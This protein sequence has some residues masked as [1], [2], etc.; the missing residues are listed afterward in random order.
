MDRSL[1]FTLLLGLPTLLFT[2]PATAQE[3]FEGHPS[4][5]A[6]SLQTLYG[7]MEA[8]P[9]HMA[10]IDGGRSGQRALHIEGGEEKMIE[11]LLDERPQEE[12]TLHFWLQRVTEEEPFSLTVE[13]LDE[14][15]RTLA[16][17]A[18]PGAKTGTWATEVK[19]TLPPATAAVRISC[20][21]SQGGGANIDDLSISGGTVM[22][23]GD[24]YARDPGAL[25][26]MKGRCYN[27]VYGLCIPTTGSL[28][29]RRLNRVNVRFS[30]SPEDIEAVT[31]HIGSADPANL[32]VAR[33]T[34]GVSIKPTRDK[35]QLVFTGDWPL[36]TGDN[37]IWISA[38]PSASADIHRT[39]SCTP[40]SIVLENTTVELP[41]T[42]E[43][44]Q[45]IGSAVCTSGDMNAKYFRLPGVIRTQKGTLVACFDARYNH[46]GNLPA[47]IDIAFSRSEDGGQTWSPPAVAMDTGNNPEAGYDG[48]GD[49]CIL[50]DAQNGRIWIAALWVHGNW[51]HAFNGS[52][53]GLSPDDT[54][55][56]VMVTSDDDGR[57]WSRKIINITPQIKNP[58]WRLVL[59]GPGMGICTTKG[60][61]VFPAQYR[62]AENDAEQGKPFSTICTSTDGGQTWKFG[63]GVRADTTECQVVELKDGSLMLNCKDNRGLYRTVAV[64][65]DLG[66]T[67]SAHSS[68]RKELVDPICQA[69]LIAV[70]HTPRGRRL[71]FSNPATPGGRYNLSIRCSRDEGKRWG[72]PHT[73]DYRTLPG[74]SCLVPIDDKHL[75][76]MY[77]S[78]E[79]INFLS[80]P[81][82][83]LEPPA[84]GQR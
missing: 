47:N 51:G 43:R 77:E 60:V 59:P 10:L 74:H 63:T 67:W 70:D 22:K 41:A 58:D 6:T 26:A 8:R 12:A 4:G 35:D 71:Y 72:E 79:G 25:P 39:F 33:R 17:T 76:L 11:L 23:T 20:S 38:T 56:W 83:E 53:P 52:R 55:Q 48:C 3:S 80:L 78:E 14:G 31:L 61:L 54:G 49:P 46:G 37:W 44:R 40:T 36:R 13:A 73:C 18:V 34:F 65:R 7:H 45:R 5:P 30:G 66:Q 2:T 15:R 29:P 27:P 24:A 16:R 21:S 69:S 9:T 75:G 19:A 1:L 68:D 28:Q 42:P 82:A 57:S 81:Y 84:N 64:T 62:G 50:Q 32:D